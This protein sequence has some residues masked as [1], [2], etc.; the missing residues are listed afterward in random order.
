MG[1]QVK[2]RL[3]GAAVLLLLAA[4][5]WPLL[6]NFDDSL[7]GNELVLDVEPMP[8]D[9]AVADTSVGINAKPN[10]AQAAPVPEPS[11]TERLS[12]EAENL[13]QNTA[14]NAGA[15][16]SNS[17]AQRGKPRLDSNR[18]PVSYVVQVATFNE[19]NNAKNFKESLL[20]NGL[21]AYVKPASAAQ[22]GP[23]RIAVGP[24]MTYA[25]A[26]EIS[27]RI[28]TEHKIMDAIIRRLR[29]V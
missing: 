16:V 22:P 27:R 20:G 13:L 11:I 3:V 18:V 7:G 8:S 4:L 12:A 29:D 10:P 26:E 21:K 6:F 2:R 5:V 24:V 23:Y 17:S 28:E 15:I 1:D 14:D 19:W 9:A 25:E